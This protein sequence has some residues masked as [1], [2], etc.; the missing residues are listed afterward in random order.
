M[1]F[2]AL[3]AD[4]LLIG[5]EPDGR[6]INAECGSTH[7]EA[8]IEL[9]TASEADIGFAYDGDGDRIAA[10]DGAGRAARRRRPDRADRDGPPE[11][12]ASSR[13]AWP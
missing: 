3:G 9:V 2:R 5:A 7:P 12:G 8:L 4:P 6:N 1:I 10:V 11:S 13:V